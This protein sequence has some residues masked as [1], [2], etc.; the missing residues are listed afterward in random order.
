MW[1][2]ESESLGLGVGGGFEACYGVGEEEEEAVGPDESCQALG[3]YPSMD[4]Y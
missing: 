3:R 4:T 1:V 2:F